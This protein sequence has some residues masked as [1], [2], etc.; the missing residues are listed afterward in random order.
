MN[1]EI[2]RPRGDEDGETGEPIAE[3]AA[4]REDPPDGFGLRISNSILRRLF[5]AEAADF[6]LRMLLRTMFDYLMAAID[7]FGGP[8]NDK[9]DDDG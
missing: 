3:L 2:K 7:A 4:L 9:G 5:A 8:R 1:D 6:S